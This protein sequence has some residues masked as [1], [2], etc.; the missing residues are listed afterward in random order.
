MAMDWVRAV[1]VVGFSAMAA[2]GCAS[3]TVDDAAASGARLS[4]DDPSEG[5]A[6]KFGCEGGFDDFEYFGEVDFRDHDHPLYRIRHT[7]RFLASGDV[8]KQNIALTFGDGTAWISEDNLVSH[9]KNDD[10]TDPWSDL[11]VPADVL[12][13]AFVVRDGKYNLDSVMWRFNYQFRADPQC[14]QPFYPPPSQKYEPPP[15]ILGVEVSGFVT[16][17][18]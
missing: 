10:A 17:R 3:S 6:P 4:G 11:P 9:L 18:I 5:F 2:L 1:A 14:T 16:Q 13:R 12:E 7:K 15:K 8:G